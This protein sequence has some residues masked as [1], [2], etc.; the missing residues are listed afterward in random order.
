MAEHEKILNPFVEAIARCLD[1]A[2]AAYFSGTMTKEEAVNYGVE[3][4]DDYT[5]SE[6]F[7]AVLDDYYD[8]FI[9]IK[10]FNWGK[11]GELIYGNIKST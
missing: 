11:E 3:L 10:N 7:K 5:E 4:I 2:L 1:T 9:S 8:S 6:A